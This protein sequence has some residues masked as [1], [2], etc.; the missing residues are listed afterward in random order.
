MNRLKNLLKVKHC[1]EE[2]LANLLG[3]VPEIVFDWECGRRPLDE[4]HARTICE[5]FN[6][7]LEY[8][9]GYYFKTTLPISQWPKDRQE[10]YH[11]ADPALREYMECLYGKPEYYKEK[12]A[13][14]GELEMVAFERN[15][16]RIE[17]RLTRDVGD[18]LENYIKQFQS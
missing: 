15:E 12:P 11:N 13:D 9:L 14:E 18:H 10:D 17:L 2:Q 1:T 16:K 8:L 4:K 7:P 5:R 6:A 3:I